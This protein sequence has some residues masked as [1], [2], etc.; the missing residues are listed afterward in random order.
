MENYLPTVKSEVRGP[1]SNVEGAG[2][3]V[4]AVPTVFAAWTW[5]NPAN[6]LGLR[7]FPTALNNNNPNSNGS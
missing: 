4:L 5:E 6:T 3:G 2:R 1:R 7:C